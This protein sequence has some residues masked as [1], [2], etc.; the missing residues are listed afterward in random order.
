MARQLLARGAAV[1]LAASFA[2]ALLVTSLPAQTPENRPQP[3][4]HTLK[5]PDVG[6]PY[7]PEEGRW[8]RQYWAVPGPQGSLLRGVVLRPRGN[9]P[10]PLAVISHGTSQGDEERA[11]Y[12]LPYAV[13]VAEWLL[14]KG[15]VVAMMHRRG[16]GETTTPFMERLA[17]NCNQRRAADYIGSVAFAAEDIQALVAHM[18]QQ[19]FT[20]KGK[21]L[22]VGHSGGGMASLSR[23]ASRPDDILAVINFAGARGARPHMSPGNICNEESLNGAFADFGR[24]V[25]A[26]T[27]WIYAENDKS[28]VPAQA[29]RFSESFKAAGGRA[30]LVITPPFLED[31]HVLPHRQGGQDLWRP[32][33]EAFM[34]SLPR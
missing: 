31:G 32:A 10:F 2:S 21:V 20:A 11:R 14:D 28:V 25:K 15:Y 30:E 8:R 23:A 19:S 26:P 17:G 29:R 18:Q 6:G 16:V 5:L 3:F 7:G 4:G 34:A 27:L 9:G 22:L 12:S 13:P 33:L 24:R 1:I